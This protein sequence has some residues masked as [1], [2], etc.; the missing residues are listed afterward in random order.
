IKAGHKTTIITAS[1]SHFLKKYP[2]MDGNTYQTEDIDGIQYLWI[3]ALTYTK[4]FDKKRVLKWFQFAFRLFFVARKLE[5][6][7]DVILCSPTAPFSILPAYFL[8]KKFRAKLV[9][10]V[11]DIWP[12]TLIEIGGFSPNHPLIILMRWFEKFAL[13]KSDIIVS[14]LMNYTDHIHNLGLDREANWVSNGIDVGEMKKIEPLEKSVAKKVPKA[15][16]IV[17][18]TGKLGVSNALDHL[19]ESARLLKD[20]K[21]IAFVIVGDGQEKDALIESAKDLENVVFIDS[22]DKTQVQSMLVSFD[23]CYI[24]WKKEE[25]YRFGTSANKVFDYMYSGKPIIQSIDA[26]SDVVQVAECGLSV[27]A[28]DSTEIA[29]AILKVSE[30]TVEERSRLGSN[31]QKYVLEHFTYEKLAQKYLEI[32]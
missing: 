7:P 6:K 15:K 17:G 24:G 1:Y 14:N 26:N 12:L 19:I 4:S 30:M 25:L 16:F 29:D 22:I 11:R 28:E 20:N 9:F 5:D 31:G 27:G 18:Y 21:D 32:F 3:K 10:E 23:V 2:K 8:A 13:K